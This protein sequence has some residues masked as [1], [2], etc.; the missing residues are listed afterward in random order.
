MGLAPTGFNAMGRTE[1]QLLCRRKRFKANGTTESMIAALEASLFSDTA[2]TGGGSAA[3][4]GG[5]DMV[6]DLTLL[7]H[8][9]LQHLCKQKKLKA[10]VTSVEMR[11]ALEASRC[12]AM[13]GSAA[14]D[15]DED[16]GDDED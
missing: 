5:D 14:E 4:D 3:E 13:A 15:D 11:T 9:E 1:L 16:V 6:L 10:N 7:N 8:K 12:S 2:A